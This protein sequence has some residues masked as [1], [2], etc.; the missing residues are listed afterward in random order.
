MRG[1]RIVT[2]DVKFKSCLTL[3]THTQEITNTPRND[4]RFDKVNNGRH[5]YASIASRIFNCKNN[6]LVVGGAISQP[7]SPRRMRGE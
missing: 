1:S 4:E 6:L 7:V 2:V 3:V 5:S